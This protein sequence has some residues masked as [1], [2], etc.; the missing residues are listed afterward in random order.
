MKLYQ[1]LLLLFS[2]FSFSQGSYNLEVKFKTEITAFDFNSELENQK[3]RYGDGLKMN[4]LGDGNFIRTYLNSGKKGNK[5]QSYNNST[6]Q[7][8]ISYNGSLVVDTIDVNHNTIQLI[9]KKEIDGESIL[10]LKC[11]CIVYSGI[12]KQQIPVKITYCYSEDSPFLDGNLFSNHNDFF[13]ADFYK[14]TN[15][16]YLKFL[17]ETSDF[18]LTFTA[19]KI[20]K[21]PL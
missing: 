3:N 2:F 14:S 5:T 21:I 18:N 8:I 19:I 15:R 17:M 13:M 12:F 11:K 1:Y 20:K 4:Y 6:G 7:L 16:P 10:K 9:Y